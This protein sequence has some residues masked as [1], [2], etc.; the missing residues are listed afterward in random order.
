MPDEALG[1]F[2]QQ[3]QRA[4]TKRERT[5]ALRAVAKERKRRRKDLLNAYFLGVVNVFTIYDLLN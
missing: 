5:L 1:Q 3:I 4:A 2:E